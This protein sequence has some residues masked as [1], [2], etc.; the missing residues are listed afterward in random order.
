M[1]TRR[2]TGRA[3]QAFT[4]T[5]RTVERSSRNIRESRRASQTAQRAQ[6]AHTTQSSQSLRASIQRTPRLQYTKIGTRIGLFPTHKADSRR[7]PP[8]ATSCRPVSPSLTWDSATC[9][10]PRLHTQPWLPT[11]EVLSRGQPLVPAPQLKPT[12][13]N[14][15]RG[16]ALAVLRAQLRRQES[17]RIKRSASADP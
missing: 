10:P 1:K 4:R 13:S 8:W 6:S 17:R 14:Q 16:G 9:A 5:S 12:R 3:W 15:R 11:E 7:V 2:R